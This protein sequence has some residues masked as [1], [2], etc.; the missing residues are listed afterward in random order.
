MHRLKAYKV[1]ADVCMLLENGV[2]LEAVIVAEL[3]IEM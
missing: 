3:R 1:Q 2:N